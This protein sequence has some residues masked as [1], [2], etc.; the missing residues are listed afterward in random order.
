[1]GTRRREK[2]GSVEKVEPGSGAIIVA[3]Q[4]WLDVSGYSRRPLLI[5]FYYTSIMN[6]CGILEES[7]PRDKEP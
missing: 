7:V 3:Q 1:M 4:V 5:F 2:W 6:V